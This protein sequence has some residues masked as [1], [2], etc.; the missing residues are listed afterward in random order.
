MRIGSR[1]G[2]KVARGR[3]GPVRLGGGRAGVV[4]LPEH[5]HV[6]PQ[7]ERADAVLRLAPLEAAKLE[8]ADVEAEVELFALYPARL[9][10]EE[11]P[12]LVDEDHEPEPEHRLERLQRMAGDPLDPPLPGPGAEEHGSGIHCHRHELTHVT[13]SCLA[14][15]S[16][17]RMSSSDGSA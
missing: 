13:T 16:S 1:F 12:Q 5:L 7:G 4:V 6:A 10:D 15:A 17:R 11:V 2:R 14:Q 8:A 9:G 3:A